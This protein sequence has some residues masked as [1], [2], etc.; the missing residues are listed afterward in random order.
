M[1]AGEV[2]AGGIARKVPPVIERQGIAVVYGHG[3]FA[4][5][6]QNFRQPLAAMVALENWC[7][8]EYLRRLS[9]RSPQMRFQ[10]TL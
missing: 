6:A 9:L 1:V 8:A 7:R 10:E 4:I 5:G 3:V 2:G